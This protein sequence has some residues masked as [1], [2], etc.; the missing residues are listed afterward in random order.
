MG[1]T[2][3][4]SGKSIEVSDPFVNNKNKFKKSFIK[5]HKPL[6]FRYASTIMADNTKFRDFV[7]TNL[8]SYFFENDKLRNVFG[9]IEGI[10]TNNPLMDS[11]HFFMWF[12]F[13]FAMLIFTFRMTGLKPLLFGI[14]IVGV[15]TLLNTLFSAIL[16]YITN[17][18]DNTVAYF[19]AYFVVLMGAIILAIPLFFAEKVKK[20]IVAICINI[21]INGFA[22]YLL[23]LL[24]IIAMHHRDQC[25]FT[26]PYGRN[27]DCVTI[28]DY[29][30]FNWS[31]VLFFAGLIFMYFYMTIIK[32]WKSLPEG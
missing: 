20:L 21:S 18:N 26:S 1:F 5:A 15:L 29:L 25:D 19:I 9:N 30:E 7:A 28:F 10:K 16:F 14:V 23:L 13:F 32:K 2:K 27:S 12:S 22:L 4:A 17:S 8:S 31:F 3:G 24:G 6:D 11:I